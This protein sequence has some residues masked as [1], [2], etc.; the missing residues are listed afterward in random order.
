MSRWIRT[1]E[2]DCSM[3]VDMLVL[4]AAVATFGI[5]GGWVFRSLWRAATLH[6]G[7]GLA[8]ARSHPRGVPLYVREWVN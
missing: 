5:T 6:Q 4:S 2:P 3:P 1:D 7:H 8:V